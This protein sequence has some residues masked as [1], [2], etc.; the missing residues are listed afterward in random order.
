M[1]PLLVYKLIA[2]ALL[3]SVHLYADK[4]RFLKAIPRSRGLSFAS[5]V[6][7][8]YVFVHLLPE[9]YHSQHTEFFTQGSFW[10]LLHSHLYFVALFSFVCYYGLERFVHLK[11][12]EE[13]E[14]KD[15]FWLHLVLFSFYNIIAMYALLSD[16]TDG[17]WALVSLTIALLFHAIVFDFG[18]VQDY[19]EL[20]RTRGKYVLT[21][22]AGLGALSSL[23][24]KLEHHHIG[25][26]TAFLAGAVIL[27][28]LK[29]ELPTNRRS[30]WLA[31]ASGSAAYAVLL[32]IVG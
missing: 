6:S 4:L 17:L 21:L 11:K 13:E 16:Y 10:N 5:G 25:V 18:A 15:A 31:F 23:L 8:A 26:A 20:Y 1:E 24:F 29:E 7:V 19:A 2:A 14:K 12:S 22:A 30:S 9:I 27:N 32:W 3:A 28:V